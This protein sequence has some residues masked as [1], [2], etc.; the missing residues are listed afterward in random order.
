MTDFETNYD[1]NE[2][3]TL[4]T[5]DEWALEDECAEREK[6]ELDFLFTVTSAKVVWS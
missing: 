2:L 5:Q 4:N 1:E 6:E 3:E